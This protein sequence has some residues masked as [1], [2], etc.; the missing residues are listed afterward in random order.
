MSDASGPV[1]GTRMAR[2]GAHILLVLLALQFLVS[3]LVQAWRDSPTVDE[4]IDVSSGVTNLAHRD[5]RL[6]PEHGAL[7]LLLSAAAARQADPVVPETEAHER[8]DWLRHTH[9]FVR[10]NLEAGKLRETF[11]LARLVPL[12]AALLGAFFLHRLGVRVGGAWGGLI[13]AA[14]WLTTPYVVGLAH[15]AVID[16]VFSV[17][18]LGVALALVRLLERPAIMRALVL[19]A[20][21]AAALLTRH[22]ALVLV[23]GSVLVIFWNQRRNWWLAVRCVAVV[24]VVS[25]LGVWVGI[26]AFDPTP[27]EGRPAER[28]RGFV[29]EA[30]EESLAAELA[31]LIP[32]P[33]EYSGGLAY[34]VETSEPRR[35]YLFGE[36]WEGSRWWFF[37]ASVLAKVP[38]PAL[39]A[40]AVG[41]AAWRHAGRSRLTRVGLPV[42]ALAI[43]LSGFLLAQPLNLGLRLALPVVALVFVAGAAVPLV[44]RGNGGRVAL[45]VLLL[46]QTGAFWW[47][48]PHS[49]AWAQPPFRPAYRYLSDSNLDYSQDLYRLE[50]WVAG[51]DREP[52]VWLFRPRGWLAPDAVRSLRGTP[53]SEI[54]GWVAVSATALTVVHRDT[55]S[56]LRAYCP[57][58]VIGRSILVYRFAEPPDPTPGPTMPAAPCTGRFSTR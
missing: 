33:L 30:R 10:D 5:L 52:Y 58:D 8:G 21:L 3:G 19:G 6:A 38:L 41:F 42:A 54:R 50:E 47:A 20:G 23:A 26:R 46:A 15:F 32:W 24:A 44:L 48:H 57:V 53:V 29:A 22:T 36:A 35:A 37:P 9:H 25:W 28:L 4:A 12:T 51:S 34:L 31:L 11:F 56:W 40:V 18:T 49:L 17:A 16:V 13:A 1:A 2:R 27:A 7:P 14:L 43:A 45:A 55:L 39:V